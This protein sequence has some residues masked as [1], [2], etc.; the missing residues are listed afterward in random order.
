MSHDEGMAKQ[1]LRWCLFEGKS[2]DEEFDKHRFR[3][4]VAAEDPNFERDNPS[5]NR[6]DDIMT[7]ATYM[8]EKHSSDELRNLAACAREDRGSI[9]RWCRQMLGVEN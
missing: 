1:T 7:C 2:D 3:M 9:L 8:L 5:H 6:L 4:K